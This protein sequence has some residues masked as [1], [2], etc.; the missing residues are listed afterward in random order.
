MLGH[1]SCRRRLSFAPVVNIRK[2]AVALSYVLARAFGAP[3]RV[4]L[5]SIKNNHLENIFSQKENEFINQAN[6]SKENTEQL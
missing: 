3:V 4:V 1:R 6:P 2:R 5:D